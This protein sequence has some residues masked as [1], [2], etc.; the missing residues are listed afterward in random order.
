VKVRGGVGAGA[1]APASLVVVG[2]VLLGALLTGCASPATVSPPPAPTR[3]QRASDTRAELGIRWA[4]ITDGAPTFIEPKVSVVKYSTFDTVF[5]AVAACMRSGNYPKVVATTEGILDPTLN[6]A[7]EFPF[8]VATWMCE[9]QY[10]EEPVELG[11]LTPAQG[12][13]L[14]GYWQQRLVPCL[15]SHG[16][17]VRDLAV[18][19]ATPTTTAPNTKLVALNPYLALTL[20]SGVSRARLESSC[21]AYPSAL[22]PSE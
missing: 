9:A 21:P 1:L 19:P 22:V 10:P 5:E 20:P 2:V 8:E 12:R 4:N 15:R 7:E 18:M 17:V 6:P 14:Y 13:Y 11:Y 3:A 16:A